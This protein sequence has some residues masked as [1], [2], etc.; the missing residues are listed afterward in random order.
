MPIEI[1]IGPPVL[2]INQGSTFL[3]TDLKGEIAASSRPFSAY[4]P[5]RQERS[6]PSTRYYQPGYQT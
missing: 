1:T 2:T 6:W 3:V 4:K 5:M